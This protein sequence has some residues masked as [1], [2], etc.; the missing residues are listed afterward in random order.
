MTSKKEGEEERKGITI[1]FLSKKNLQG[2][3]FNEKL[4]MI[5]EKVRKEQIL[6]LEE[7]LTPE[8]KS[9]LIE[10]S[11]ENVDDD[12]PGIEFSGFDPEKPWYQK[13]IN[14]FIGKEPKEGLLI[15][16]SSNILEK[17]D[18]E[19]DSISLFAKLGK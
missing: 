15:V 5:M 17:V 10:K 6:V 2:K 11:M 18:E 9:K 13:F 14:R 3:D 7:A 8:E 12:F 16:G 19:R 4:E 1:E